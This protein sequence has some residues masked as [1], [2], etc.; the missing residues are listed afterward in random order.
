MGNNQMSNQ[1]PTDDELQQIRAR[2]EAAT[3]GPWE[4]FHIEEEDR[5]ATIRRPIVGMAKDAKGWWDIDSSILSEP[6]ARFIA[7]ARVDIPALLAEVERL[8]TENASLRESLDLSDLIINS[9]A[10]K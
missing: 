4:V 3:P 8:R 5:R 2:A 7:H 10:V 1:P 9:E 6:D